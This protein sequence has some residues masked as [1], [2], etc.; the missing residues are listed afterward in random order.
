MKLVAQARQDEKGLFWDS[1]G[2]IYLG[3]GYGQTGVALFLVEAI[4]GH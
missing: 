2:E 3:L 1:D 4:A